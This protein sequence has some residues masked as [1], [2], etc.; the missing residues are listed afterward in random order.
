M[1]PDDVRVIDAAD[2]NERAE[3][4]LVSY[5]VSMHPSQALFAAAPS[6]VVHAVCDAFVPKQASQRLVDL[7]RRCTRWGSA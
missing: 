2:R 3:G 7:R 6:K 5:V 1:Q 4:R